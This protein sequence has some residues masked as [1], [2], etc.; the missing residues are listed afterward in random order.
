MAKQIESGTA[1]FVLTLVA[2][3]S[4][5]GTTAILTSGGP[6]PFITGFTT[7]GANNT[8][9]TASVNVSEYVIMSLNASVLKF[10]EDAPLTP[11]ASDDTTDGNPDPLILT[12]DGNIELNVSVEKATDL[13]TTDVAGSFQIKVANVT[14][15]DNAGCNHGGSGRNVTSFSDINSTPNPNQIIRNIGYVAANDTCAIHLKITVPSDEPAGNYTSVLKFTGVS[16]GY[17]LLK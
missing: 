5:L 12:N 17:L 2:I 16:R 10:G 15:G 1:A 11:G 3:V 14:A 9:A 4:V 8:T 7:A 13:F 6:V